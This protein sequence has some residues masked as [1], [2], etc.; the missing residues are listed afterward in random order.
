MVAVQRFILMLTQL[1]QVKTTD[2]HHAQAHAADHT[3]GTDD[4]QNAT[5]AQKGLATATQITKLDGIEALADV[6]DSG[7]VN[8]AGATM[9]ADTDVKANG[10]GVDEDTMVSNLDTKVPTQQSVEA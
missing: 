10:Y 2:D 7:N 1:Q 4:I 6:T 3:D 5:A 9:N 8:A